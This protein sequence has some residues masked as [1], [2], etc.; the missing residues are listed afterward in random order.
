M[1]PVFLIQFTF[2]VDGDIRHQSILIQP[3]IPHS[4]TLPPSTPAPRA[5]NQTRS[6]EGPLFWFLSRTFSITSRLI[7]ARAEKFEIFLILKIKIYRTH[8][9]NDVG[10]SGVEFSVVVG[11]IRYRIEVLDG[12]KKHKNCIFGL[13]SPIN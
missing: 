6:T 5:S 13:G 11:R 7:S 8:V 12:K 2:G 10:V 9:Q 1:A 3:S 4:F